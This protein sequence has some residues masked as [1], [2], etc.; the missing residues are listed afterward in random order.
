MRP[1]CAKASFH[2]LSVRL[3]TSPNAPRF[4]CPLIRFDSPNT[5]AVDAAAVCT[6]MD[7]RRRGHA[8]DAALCPIS[9]QAM[10]WAHTLAGKVSAEGAISGLTLLRGITEKVGEQPLCDRA[11][12]RCR[13]WHLG[14]GPFAS[15]GRMFNTKAAR[16]PT[17]K[18]DG[19]LFAYRGAGLASR[20]ENDGPGPALP[21]SRRLNP[22]ATHPHRRAGPTST[23]PLPPHLTQRRRQPTST[24]RAPLAA[25]PDRRQWCHRRGRCWGQR[26]QID[27]CRCRG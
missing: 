8:P 19:P 16:H 3:G 17:D 21:D 4:H 12:C 22:R 9:D 13:G 2:L 6:V 5:K 23:E 10:R 7:S 1:H 20:L 15:G 26:C 18:G 11:Q 24:N 25:H 27:R 14:C